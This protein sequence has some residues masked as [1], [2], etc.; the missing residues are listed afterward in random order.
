[1]G[2]DLSYST[3]LCPASCLDTGQMGREQISGS[4]RFLGGI[5]GISR[6]RERDLGTDRWSSCA[7]PNGYA[8][9][10]SRSFISPLLRDYCQQWTEREKGGAA[11]DILDYYSYKRAVHCSGTLTFPIIAL[12][13]FSKKRLK[14]RPS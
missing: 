12:G 10:K 1:M 14:D 4:W 8:R 11:A 3:A 7:W 6:G 9:A 5:W 13:H 2:G